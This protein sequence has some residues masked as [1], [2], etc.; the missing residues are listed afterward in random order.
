MT[1]LAG[2]HPNIVGLV[3]VVVSEEGDD[4]PVGL[5]FKLHGM[6]LEDLLD[7]VK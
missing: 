5:I 7:T 4:R 1:R 6:S 2:G 3:G